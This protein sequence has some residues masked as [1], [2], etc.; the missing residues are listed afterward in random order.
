M[1]SSPIPKLIRP[2]G[3]AR[4]V[5]PNREAT[6]PGAIT[7]AKANCG[8][9]FYQTD[10]GLT[11]P[12]GPGQMGDCVELALRSCIRIIGPYCGST[13]NHIA[14]IRETVDVYQP[15]ERPAFEEIGTRLDTSVRPQQAARRERRRATG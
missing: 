5:Q 15:G 13:P 14:A 12:I 1:S 9:P 4:A 3:I 10:G 11:Y 2:S 7:I 8:I 6:V